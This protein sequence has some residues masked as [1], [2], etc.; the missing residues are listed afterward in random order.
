MK[1]TNPCSTRIPHPFRAHQFR[2]TLGIA[3]LLVASMGAVACS[4]DPYTQAEVPTEGGIILGPM[5]LDAS[6]LATDG[7]RDAT[8]GSDADAGMTDL[9]DAAISQD[10]ASADAPSIDDAPATVDAPS[11]DDA[12]ATV[13]AP[14]SGDAQPP[15]DAQ[16]PDDAT[17][18]E[19]AGTDA[20]ID[21]A[22]PCA[23]GFA[24]CDGNLANGCETDLATNPQHC[25]SCGE[26]C[27]ALANV[28]GAV[29]CSAGACVVPSTS[30]AGGFAHCSSNVLDGCETDIATNP[31]HCGSCG[32]NCS[33]LA[34]ISGTVSCSASACVVPLSSCQAG[35]AHCSSSVLDG[36]ETDIATNP[37]HCGSC[38]E[39]CSAL[40]HV[41]GTVSCSASACVVP[42]SSCQAGFA[43]CSSS[44]LDGCETDIATNPQHCGSCGEDCSAL[45]HVSGTVSCSATTCVVPAS[46]CQA[47]FAHCSSNALDGC[48]TDLSNAAHCGTCGTTCSGA[49]P[50][51]SPNGAGGYA[52][53]S[54]C[55]SSAPERC[56]MTC[57][58]TSDDVNNCRTCGDACIAPTHGTPSCSASTCSYACNAGF[59][60]C[61]SGAA[62]TCSDNA[63]PSS[64]GTSCTACPSGPAGSTPTCSGTSCGYACNAGSHQCGSGASTTC[65]ANTSVNSCG[66]SCT[67][68]PAGP[69]AS[70]PT[71]DGTNCGFACVA[72]FHE[73]QSQVLGGAPSC[74]S[75]TSLQS[76]GASCPSVSNQGCSVPPSNGQATCDG[77][78]CGVTCD[79]GYSLCRQLN[80]IG[81]RNVACCG[82]GT[83]CD[84]VTGT[85]H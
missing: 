8:V 1:T 48:E 19:D 53:S 26:D 76:C 41:S 20:G 59:H 14:S 74:D 2:R 80:G 70:N 28:S 64:C 38:G 58:D 72:G 50:V 9:P 11:I 83:T 18:P 61:G 60:E 56:G 31:Q 46:S 40:A 67:T 65:D 27:A 17:F 10:A 15:E 23:T 85:C 55:P 81:H 24:D 7:G 29:S 75:N 52:C 45:A 69:A 34:H 6:A 79:S 30:C 42:A 51:C 47:G 44:V 3:T 33:A 62:A 36:C 43:H 4:S 71:C 21:S 73:C 39:D 5:P 25:G 82:G 57:T 54:G 66:S 37:Q 63:S 16:A 22:A 78:N 13:D 12:P 68:C 77:T 84:T 49:T 32:E 35:F